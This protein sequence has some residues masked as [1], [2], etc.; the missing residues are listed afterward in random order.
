MLPQ[1]SPYLNIYRQ[2]L[3]G[4]QS[5]CSFSHVKE[6]QRNSVLGRNG[7]SRSYQEPQA[8]LAFSSTILSTCFLK[9]QE[10]CGTS[11]ITSAFQ[12]TGQREKGKWATK[13]HLAH[14]SLSRLL[15]N[16]T[17]NI[18]LYLIGQESLEMWAINGHIAVPNKLGIL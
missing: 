13:G 14:L 11:A 6:V 15:E 4:H 1:K 2:P 16:C 17:Y 12:A 10:G 5:K 8:A 18:L 9:V 3:C 7:G